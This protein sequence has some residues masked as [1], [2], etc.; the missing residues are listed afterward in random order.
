LGRRY[1]AASIR[2]PPS[3]RSGNNPEDPAGAAL[4]AALLL[5]LLLLREDNAAVVA[6]ADAAATAAATA[7]LESMGALGAG[8]NDA[9]LPAIATRDTALPPS[10]PTLLPPPRFFN[11]H[12]C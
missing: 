1:D 10:L 11:L 3:G 6:A 12:F 7:D 9:M 2:P 8:A 5:L 4:A